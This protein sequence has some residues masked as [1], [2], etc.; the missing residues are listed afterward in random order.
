MKTLYKRFAKYYDLVYSKKDYNKEVKFIVQQIKKNK[1]KGKQVLDVGCGTGNHDVILRKKGFRITGIDI[2]K[3]MLKLAKKKV[4]GKFLEGDMRA[5]NIK[6]KFDIIL[7]LFST[8]HYNLNYKQ[9]EKTLKNFYMHLKEEGILIFDM[10]FNEERWKK[11]GV[12]DIGH[13][14][15]KGVH[16]LRF[17]KSREQGKYG[18]LDMGYIVYKNNKFEFAQEQHKIRRFETLKVKR[19]LERIG[20]KIKI[21][22][23]YTNKLW[24]KKSKK[25]VVF[26]AR[27]KE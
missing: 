26:V 6:K 9:L 10:G 2:N 14:Q 25:Y 20:F 16:V 22:E 17:S 8:I 19:L 15:D 7:C 18:I 3:E 23:D 12:L 11:G 13:F 4:K 24:S 1:I 21:Y 27:K 5:F